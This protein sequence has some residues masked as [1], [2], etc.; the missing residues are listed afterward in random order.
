MDEERIVEEAN[1]NM[2]KEAA[3]AM[4][5]KEKLKANAAL[6]AAE[7]AIKM[8]EKETQRRIHAEMKARRE[9]QEKYRALDQL[10]SKD[11]RVRKYTIHD[12]EVATQ[13]FSQTFK[14]GEGGYGPVFKGKL[15]NT[16][17]AIKILNPKAVHG[18]R[19][20][21]QEVSYMCTVFNHICIYAI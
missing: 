1:I 7:E 18:R 21:Q 11:I 10:A 5:E 12:I 17:V 3:L 8:V 4:A 2:S 15:D 9:A 19:Q 20:F 14:V 13:N 16:Q 6:E